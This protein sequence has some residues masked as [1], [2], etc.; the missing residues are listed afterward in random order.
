[1]GK[2]AQGDKAK[3][4]VDNAVSQSLL[5]STVCTDLSKLLLAITGNFDT[6]VLVSTCLQKKCVA[7]LAECQDHITQITVDHVL[8]S[9]YCGVSLA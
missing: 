8:L 5:G 2:S 3:Q 7:I 6:F 1:M 4:R 9:F